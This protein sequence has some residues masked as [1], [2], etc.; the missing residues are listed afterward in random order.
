[1]MNGARKESTNTIRAERDAAAGET[2]ISQ[3][4]NCNIEIFLQRTQTRN[5][6][7]LIARHY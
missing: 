6:I 1:M 5:A 7:E 2:E 3:P 4:E